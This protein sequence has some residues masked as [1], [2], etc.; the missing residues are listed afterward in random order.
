[1]AA[2]KT[3]QM[4]NYFHTDNGDAGCSSTASTAY[5]C[6][7]S[8]LKVTLPKNVDDDFDSGMAFL[9]QNILCKQ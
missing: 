1:V 6:P 4:N 3:K 8:K 9:F 2:G 5:A 7:N